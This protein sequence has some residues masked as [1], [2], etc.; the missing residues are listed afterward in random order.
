MIRGKQTM[1]MLVRLYPKK[2]KEGLWNCV[3]PV[4][5]D[6]KSENCQPLYLSEW[7]P[8]DFITVMFDVCNIDCMFKVWTK[9]LSH[10]QGLSHTRTLTLMSPTFFPVPKKRPENLHR[11]RIAIQVEI[12]NMDSVFTTLADMSFH[13]YNVFP[14][15]QAY[16]FG[17]DDILLSVLA[18]N[19]ES[20]NKTIQE[21]IAPMI[22]VK[23]VEYI[24]ITKSVRIA[25]KNIWR[26]YRKK[27][28]KIKSEDHAQELDEDFDW[29]LSNLAGLTG[30]FIDEL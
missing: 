13:K 28:Y 20:I 30:A 16:S 17:E 24:W 19:E 18:E 5:Q 23:H 27:L 21:Y 15:Y 8:V 26:E 3:L 11:Y 9:E 12:A 6:M 25:P 2:D 22:G 14:T 29:S 10:C 4:L 7:E 1:M